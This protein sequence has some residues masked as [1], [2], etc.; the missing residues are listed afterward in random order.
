MGLLD[1]LVQVFYAPK[2]ER[3]FN[4]PES[5][6]ALDPMAPD[7]VAKELLDTVW[8]VLPEENL[9]HDLREASNAVWDSLPEHVRGP[10]TPENKAAFS[11]CLQG[12]LVSS[13]KLRRWLR[14]SQRAIASRA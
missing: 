10:N 12:F 3:T 1:R 13:W 11:G 5:V 8:K 2:P 9:P 6:V 14:N 4:A 7:L